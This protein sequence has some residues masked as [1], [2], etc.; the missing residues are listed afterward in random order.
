MIHLR[1]RLYTDGL[2]LSEDTKIRALIQVFSMIPHLYIETAGERQMV[3]LTSVHLDLKMRLLGL[4]LRCNVDILA[5]VK[6][7]LC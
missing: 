6:E 1:V 2:I 5:I 4:S 3:Y 7:K